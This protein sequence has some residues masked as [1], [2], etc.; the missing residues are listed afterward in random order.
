M[1]YEWRKDGG[2]DEWR[3]DERK[4][5]TNGEWRKDSGRRIPMMFQS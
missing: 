4:K 2:N 3:K 5:D 1:K